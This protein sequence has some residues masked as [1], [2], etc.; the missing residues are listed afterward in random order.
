MRR[1]A[2]IEL[3]FPVLGIHRGSPY[4]KT[5][6]GT[7]EIGQNVRTYDRRIRSGG[8]KR[9]G[10]LR[11]FD[12][13]LGVSGARQINAMIP[14]RLSQQAA[15]LS[16]DDAPG[17]GPVPERWVG[18]GL[19]V[20]NV[21][22]AIADFNS[23]RNPHFGGRFT[24]AGGA[25]AARAA[26]WNRA[27]E[28]WAELDSSFSV[29]VQALVAGDIGNGFRLY[30]GTSNTTNEVYEWDG[31]TLTAI[32]NVN[33]GGVD[34]M[35]IYDDG[36]GPKLYVAGNFTSVSSVSATRIAAYTAGTDSWSAL[37]TGLNGVANA[38]T[39][40]NN[41]TGDVLVAGGSFTTAGGAGI[42]RVATWNGSSWG[43]L[44]S[45]IDDTVNALASIDL[46]AGETLYA[47]GRFVTVEGGTVAR[48]IAAWNGS[49]WEALEVGLFDSGFIATANNNI[50]VNTITLYDDGS[51]PAVWVGGAFDIAGSADNLGVAVANLAKW[52]GTAWSSPPRGLASSVLTLRAVGSVFESTLY[53]GGS[54][55]TASV[56]PNGGMVTYDG[57]DFAQAGFVMTASASN[58]NVPGMLAATVAGLSGERLYIGLS[59]SAG[60]RV[61]QFGAGSTPITDLVAA[62]NGSTLSR[63]GSGSWT[64]GAGCYA[65]AAWDDGGGVTELYA[66]G[67]FTSP[68]TRFVKYDGAS[69]AT[70]STGAND[71]VRS[72]VVWDDGTG[73]ALFIGGDF[74]APGNA[75]GGWDGASLFS[76]TASGETANGVNGD[77]Y[78]LLPTELLGSS[79]ALVLAGEFTTMGDSTSADRVGF[80]NPAAS[81]SWNAMG[82]GFDARVQ[83]LIEFDGS[84]YAGGDFTVD[85]GAGTTTYNHVARWN[86]S[87]W[88]AVGD[89]FDDDVNRF[90][91]YNGRLYAIGQF[92]ASGAQALVGIARLNAAKTGWESVTDEDVK[93]FVG[94]ETVGGTGAVYDGLLYVSL[95][96]QGVVGQDVAYAA[97]AA[98]LA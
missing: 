35:T 67:T 93:G 43:A 52:D 48:R 66:G 76:L 23:P 20:N 96:A 21:V 91:V 31:S 38:L 42:P 53:A 97:E 39:V 36:S 54:F 44:G 33:A 62:W 64:S 26:V 89:G 65:L 6:R 69:W 81:G 37:G 17:P 92:D 10:L 74:T 94:I 19:G 90:V 27:T 12:E 72:I 29:D 15:L 79:N 41:G 78:A 28:L 49:A 7:C 25:A 85:G 50:V 86:G 87:A 8:G 58:G 9:P 88:V 47:G 24:T 70:V 5:P 46:G 2:P 63:V 55:E 14:W 80:W 11:A 32:G 60:S 56:V 83:A 18:L 22:E 57:S 95:D 4:T 68:G 77:V 71:G 13:Q 34:A 75:V 84:I 3:L 61:F 51:G 30:I 45:G 1:F 73:E 98:V 82:D 40:W 59:S 16:P